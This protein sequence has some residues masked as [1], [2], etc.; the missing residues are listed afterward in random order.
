M[1]GMEGWEGVVRIYCM[2]QEKNKKKAELGL[3][4]SVIF[5]PGIILKYYYVVCM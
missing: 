5:F 2:R 4:V 3:H 1:G